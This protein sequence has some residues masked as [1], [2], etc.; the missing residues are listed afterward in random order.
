[1]VKT[2]GRIGGHRPGNEKFHDG[3]TNTTPGSMAG[4]G[5]FLIGAQLVS[6]VSHTPAGHEPHLPQLTSLQSRGQIVRTGRN[7]DT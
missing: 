5:S 1:M 6:V 3:A 4:A 7:G 2:V